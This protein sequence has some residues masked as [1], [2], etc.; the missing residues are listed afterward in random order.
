MPQDGAIIDMSTRQEV[1]VAVSV[2]QIRDMLTAKEALWD[3]P[4]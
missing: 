4:W 3:T 2:G 1:H